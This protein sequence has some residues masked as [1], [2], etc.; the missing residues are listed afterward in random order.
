[1]PIMF[2]TSTNIRLRVAVVFTYTRNCDRA[3][4]GRRG[5]VD[6]Q[7]PS[8]VPSHK[9]EAM[10]NSIPPR[11]LITYLS[12]ALAFGWPG[13]TMANDPSYIKQEHW[14]VL[15][16]W[17]QRNVS[18]RL[19][20]DADCNCPEDLKRIR[21]VSEGVWKAQPKYHPFYM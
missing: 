20:T 7:L 18:H 5:Q 14:K 6:T 4:E 17:L 16:I 11:R 10:Y 9:R 1:M 13:W 15:S 19:A 8:V 12:M 21:T 3:G 2:R